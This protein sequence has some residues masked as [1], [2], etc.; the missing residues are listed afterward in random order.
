MLFL[1]NSPARTADSM[2]RENESKLKIVQSFANHSKMLDLQRSLDAD[3]VNS[4]FIYL[5][6]VLHN[7][8]P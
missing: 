4:K 7:R 2:R 3:E 8:A 1:N 5:V 6:L